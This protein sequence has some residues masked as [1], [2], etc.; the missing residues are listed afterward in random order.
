MHPMR[1][2]VHEYVTVDATVTSDSF[3]YQELTMADPGKIR[4]IVKPGVAVSAGDVLGYWEGQ[5]VKAEH[6][7]VFREYSLS[8]GD[9]YL[10][11]DTFEKLILV[12]DVDELSLSYL[13]EATGH[14]TTEAGNKVTLERVSPLPNTDGTTTV[15][16][17]VAEAEHYCGQRVKNLN[18]NTGR[19]YPN[20]LTLDSN[21]VY[22]KP[23]EPGIYY[24]REV[25]KYG[26]FV[27]EH[28]VTVS[29]KGTSF[30]S[31]MGVSEDKYYDNGYKSVIEG[32]A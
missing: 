31:V 6:T 15:H 2:D 16:L 4:W 3:A 13:E 18:I 21:C 9:A 19:V 17:T 32:G 29:Y 8:S 10:R 12:C 14:L 1:N 30:V 22:Q 11:F 5:P 24:V 23:G 25:T 7:G 20:V 26:T 28:K 27:A